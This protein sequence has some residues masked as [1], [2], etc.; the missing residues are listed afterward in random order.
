M[1]KDV[2]EKLEKPFKLKAREGVGGKIFKYVPSEDIVDRM[3]KI[4][5]GNWSTEVISSEIVEDSV[6]V[7]VRVYVTD[8]TKTDKVYYHDGY[9]SHFLARYTGGINKGKIIDVGNSYR[10]AVSKAIKTAC[11]RWGVAL[12]LEGNESP[13]SDDD[14]NDV[15]ATAAEF[16]PASS[17]TV[18]T[19]AIPSDIPMVPNV[20]DPVEVRNPE[21]MERPRPWPD[22]PEMKVEKDVVKTATNPI[23]TDDTIMPS[24]PTAENMPDIPFNNQPQEVKEDY[25]E[26]SMEKLTSVQKV[27]IETVMSVN[28]LK[29][30]ELVNKALQRQDNLPPKIDDVSYLDAVTIIQYGNHLRPM[31]DY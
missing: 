26:N 7:C 25:V 27:A 12:Y 8:N 10:S 23:F 24:S 11:T 21:K 6:L 16:T 3:N 30:D 18:V 17:K 4:F 2:L 20:G 28:N 9:A 1:H 14:S 13:S 19:P 15:T 31:Q 29:F 22:P 5:I